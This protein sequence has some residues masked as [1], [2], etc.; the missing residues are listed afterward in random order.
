M[1]PEG[2]VETVTGENAALERDIA[3]YYDMEREK[4]L[5][6]ARQAGS[7]HENKKNK[8]YPDGLVWIKN[9]RVYVKNEGKGGMPPTINPS[10][11]VKLYINGKECRHLT[12]IS[13]SD[14]VELK[15]VNIELDLQSDVEISEDKLKCF[16]IFT[17]ARLISHTILDSGPVNKLDLLTKQIIIETK[18]T[19][20]QQIIDYLKSVGIV[21]GISKYTLEKIC[22]NNEPGRFL[23]AEG[24]PPEDPTDDFIEYFFKGSGTEKLNQEENNMGNIDFKNILKYETVSTGQTIAQ[25]H[26]GKPGKSGISVTGEIILPRQPK[27]LTI[28]PTFSIN[29]DNK[30]GIVKATK[31]GRPFRQEKGNTITIQIYDCVLLDEVSIKT[32]NIRFKGDIEVKTNVCESME[33][34][35]RQ[36]VLVRGNVDFASIYAGNNITIKGTA[37]SSKINAALSNVVSMD[38]AP[39]MEKLIDGID[40]LIHNMQLLSVKD[41]NAAQI[42]YLLLYLLNTKNK[43][44]P[45]LIYEVLQALRKGNYDIEDEFILSLMKKT[46]LLMGNYSNI[47]DIVF[48]YDLVADLKALFLCRKNVPLKGDV[49]LNSITNC[50]VSALGNVTILGRGCINSKIYCN[51]KVRVDGYVR[52]GQIRAEKGIEINVAGSQRGSKIL[53][54]VPGDSY[55]LIRSA[56]EDTTIK[57]G[58]LSHTFYSE[59]KM[60]RARIENGKL[61]F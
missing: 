35:A 27:E 15:T 12:T 48:L 42:N 57:V 17:P 61:L 34:I 45:A 46:N 5:A 7:K 11:G 33:V 19:D 37:I 21:Y 22:K 58:N 6:V 26:K 53:L 23:V 55:I 28:V 10:D 30:T 41:M 4:A 52:G 2:K 36:N 31:T 44:L 3:Y 59:K 29:F 25:L 50:D 8:V 18:K 51:G 14:I 60:V 39:L 20:I 43:D 32:G 16:L 56:Y 38:P 47:T 40:K 1:K 24:L 54:V 13:E 49:I 9:G